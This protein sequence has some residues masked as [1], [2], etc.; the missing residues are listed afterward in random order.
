[1]TS[2]SHRLPARRAARK[3]KP[4]GW[5]FRLAAYTILVLVLLLGW[6]ELDR[7]FAPR[8]NTARERFDAILVFGCKAAPSGGPSACELA[9]VSEAVHEYR[10]GVA[11]RLILT[12]GAVHNQYIES[13]VMA[14]AARAEG[15]PDSA[16]YLDTESRD[17]IQNAKN[18]LRILQS[19]GWSSAELVSSPQHLPRIGLIFKRLP[20]EWRLHAAPPLEPESRLKASL[21]SAVEVLKTVHFLLWG[22]HEFS[23]D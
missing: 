9:R 13:K 23:A 21:L 8:S 18:A 22:R 14:A 19:H 16:L 7:R 1:L 10:R 6:A 5:R 2:R 11:P 17:T 12:G 20:V 3:R 15:I 4:L